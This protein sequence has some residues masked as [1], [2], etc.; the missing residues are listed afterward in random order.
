MADQRITLAELEALE[1]NLRAF[2]ERLISLRKMVQREPNFSGD[3]REQS[4]WKDARRSFRVMVASANPA[5][6]KRQKRASS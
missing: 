2:E 1:S 6:S 3:W 5:I 4:V